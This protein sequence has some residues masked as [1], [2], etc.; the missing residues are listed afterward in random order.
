M[1]ER[2]KQVLLECESIDECKRWTAR[3]EAIASYYRQT[4][5]E[6]LVAIAQRIKLRA[7][8]RIGE[9]LKEADV[10]IDL[11]AYLPK[12]GHAKL[13]GTSLGERSGINRRQMSAARRLARMPPTTF[14]RAVETGKP[15]PL[16]TTRKCRPREVVGVER[17]AHHIRALAA[18]IRRYPSLQV[19]V[20]NFKDMAE[21]SEFLLHYGDRSK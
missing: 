16:M 5:D 11:D 7:W 19:R 18:L 14:D 6:T 1:Y 21:V 3:A 20:D 12:G 10:T 4:Q 2:A 9:L 13:G 8:R 15:P 17:F